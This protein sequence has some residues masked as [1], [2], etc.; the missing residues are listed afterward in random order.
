MTDGFYSQVNILG[1]QLPFCIGAGPQLQPGSRATEGAPQG[2]EGGVPFPLWITVGQLLR[3]LALCPGRQHR[4]R[5]LDQHGHL[6]SSFR[7]A[8]CSNRREVGSCTRFGVGQAKTS[9]T[10]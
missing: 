5:Y 10:K 6:V 7:W 8:V 2:F 1:A 9:R 4:V 3:E